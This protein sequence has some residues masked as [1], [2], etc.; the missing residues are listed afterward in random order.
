[1]KLLDLAL[2]G[3]AAAGVIYHALAAV[4]LRRWIGESKRVMPLSNRPPVTFFRP[5][6]RGVPRLRDKLERLIHACS[7]GDQII[8]CADAGGDLEIC[9][10]VQRGHAARDIA[11]V[12]SAPSRI[13]NPKI[14]K[15]LQMSSLARHAHWIVSDSEALFDAEFVEGFCAEWIASGVA[16]MS[17]GYRFAGGTT[18][19]QR[20]DHASTLVTLWPGLAMARRLGKARFFLGACMA[21]KKSSMEAVGGW[22][23]FGDFL[24]EDNRLGAAIAEHGGILLSSQVVTLD[25]DPMN[26]RDYFSH[27]HRVAVT[28]RVAD[29]PG[30][31]AM[32]VTHGI[33]AALLLA[34][35]EPGHAWR[36][37]V[38]G[39]VLLARLATAAANARALR[40]PLRKFAPVVLIAC[41]AEPFFWLGSWLPLPVR[42]GSQRLRLARD[43]RILET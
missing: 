39:V 36:W 22:E 11:V 28:Y 18:L 2:L 1:M 21:V 6:K 12:P 35:N 29:A 10:S 15:L 20:L 40:F 34:A 27:Q 4:W 9:E 31:F 23:R 41:A 38:L 13:A 33:P 24:A 8:L 37:M 19:P 7:S 30:F 26:W 43:G 25:S 17:A 42:W 5:V 32:A 14:A 16:G 3:I